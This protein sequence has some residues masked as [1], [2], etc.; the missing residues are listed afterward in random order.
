MGVYSS[1]ETY[2][3]IFDDIDEFYYELCQYCEFD[4]DIHGYCVNRGGGND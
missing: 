3:S 2:P 4:C 1:I